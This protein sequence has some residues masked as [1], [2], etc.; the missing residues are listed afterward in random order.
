MKFRHHAKQ[1][2]SP[3]ILLFIYKHSLAIA[4]QS[5]GIFFYI[6]LAVK[7]C[8]KHVEHILICSRQFFFGS[9]IPPSFHWNECHRLIVSQFSWLLYW[10]NKPGKIWCSTHIPLLQAIW[11]LN[12]IVM[13]DFKFS[14]CLPI[15]FAPNWI[16]EVA[17]LI[18]PIFCIRNTFRCTVRISFGWTTVDYFRLAD[19]QNFISFTRVVQCWHSRWQMWYFWPFSCSYTIISKVGPQYIHNLISI[20]NV[21]YGWYLIFWKHDSFTVAQTFWLPCH[22]PRKVIDLGHWGQVRFHH[23]CPHIVIIFSFCDINTW[24]IPSNIKLL[25]IMKYLKSTLPRRV[26]PVIHD[27]LQLSPSHPRE[28]AHQQK[29]NL[30]HWHDLVHCTHKLTI[31]ESRF[32][33]NIA[34]HYSS[35]MILKLSPCCYQA[36]CTVYL[37]LRM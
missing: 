11:I 26:P 17:M 37:L 8:T 10:P 23:H 20:W 5:H 30:L 18:K 25:A 34:L 15:I 33:G 3:A 16:I 13:L 31:V 6:K 29:Q 28:N 22:I 27:C 14:I 19:N 2:T 24:F 21:L 4:Y 7:Q 35:R 36:S 32:R 1:L 9:N 12:A